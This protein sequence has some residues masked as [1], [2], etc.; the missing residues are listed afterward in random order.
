VANSLLDRIQREGGGA[1]LL[2]ILAERLSPTDLQSLLLA[3]YRRRAERQTPARLIEQYEQNRFVRPAGVDPRALNAFDRVA[4]TLAAPTFTPIELAPVC[5]LGTVSALG[6]VSQNNTVATA[7]NTEVVADSTNVLALECA[8]RRRPL[9][10]SLGERGQRVRLC[11]SHRLLRAQNFGRPGAFAHFRLFTLCSAGRG[12]AEHRFETEELT[13]H[14]GLYLGLL[15]AFGEEAGVRVRVALTDL[16]GIPAE[17]LRAGVV[18]P[19]AA[20]F[21]SVSVGFDDTRTSGRGYYEAVCFY[22][23]ATDR[24][25]TE[26][27][28]ADGGF[29]SWTRKLLSNAGERLLISGI[30]SERVCGLFGPPST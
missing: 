2:E 5:P 23:N 17:R 21:P 26:H 9:L 7:R 24:E 13:E 1:D 19:L 27:N 8:V 12:E 22:I 25:G 20:R 16:G 10:L 29:T 4:F 28:I 15:S 30:G 18:D 14:I 11:A 3:V 6:S